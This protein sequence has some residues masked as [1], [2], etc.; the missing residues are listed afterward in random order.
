MWVAVAGP[1]T[2]IP[3]VLVWL[4]LLLPAY[5]AETGSWAVRLTMPYP[6]LPHMWHAVCVGAIYVSGRGRVNSA[7]IAYRSC[8]QEA[9]KLGILRCAWEPCT[10]VGR[11]VEKRNM[12]A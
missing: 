8:H 5:H 11:D 3:M 1:L 4:L 9:I 12:Y 10:L 7:P 2:H 6:T